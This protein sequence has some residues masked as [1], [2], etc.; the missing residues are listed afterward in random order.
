VFNFEARGAVLSLTA[1]S[2]ATTLTRWIGEQVVTREARSNEL[3]RPLTV[4]HA[5]PPFHPG[6]TLRPP[7]ATGTA[8][9]DCYVDEAGRTRMAAVV[10][11]THAAFGA[12]AVDAL[13][14]WRFAPP[15]RAGQPVVVR[16][17][18]KF[19]FN[20]PGKESRGTD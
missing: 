17:R 15:T 10:E 16:M 13:V 20:A 3:D 8:L 11:A 1:A 12:A 19:L 5:A 2:A 18:Q 14:R 4:L 9:I 7:Q 6:P